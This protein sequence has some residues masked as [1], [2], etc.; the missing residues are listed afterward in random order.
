MN[1]PANIPA[2][3]CR[4]APVLK[5]R[6]QRE[7]FCGLTG[8]IWLHR[9]MQDGVPPRRGVTHLRAPAA[10]GGRRD[11]LCLAA[12]R[13]RHPRGKTDLAGMADAN[14]ELDREVARLLSRRPRYQGSCSS[15]ALPVR[16]D[17][18]R[19]SPARRSVLTQNHAPMCGCEHS[20]SGIEY[21]PSPR[22]KNA[23][24][25]LACFRFSPRT[26]GACAP[27][28]HACGCPARNVG[29]KTQA[30]GLPR[31]MGHKGPDL[32]VLPAPRSCDAP[33]S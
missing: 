30:V 16:G 4:D 31:K 1:R 15:S 14:D 20:G 32:R 17:Q 28:A 8:I 22:V 24:L 6:G 2:S 33:G 3:T 21:E 29:R 12:L 18:A 25:R 27:G 10:I 19:T 13:H 9:K 11:D 7:V 5:E 26:G 23:C